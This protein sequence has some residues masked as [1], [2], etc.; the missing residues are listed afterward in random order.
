LKDGPGGGVKR[1]N[2]GGDL[3]RFGI[4][5]NVSERDTK[6]RQ[7]GFYHHSHPARNSQ[8]T[9]ILDYCREE[10]INE[11]TIQDTMAEGHKGILFAEA[12][13]PEPVY[14]G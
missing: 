14:G 4:G 7:R 6:N 9:T 12:V 3:S 5:R 2:G 11:H 8:E 1:G 10:G 13:G